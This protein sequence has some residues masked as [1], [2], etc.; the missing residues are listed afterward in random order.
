MR[1]IEFP[2]ILTQRREGL[3][4]RKEQTFLTMKRMKNMKETIAAS[5]GRQA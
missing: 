5:A 1:V 3:K 4:G 2:N